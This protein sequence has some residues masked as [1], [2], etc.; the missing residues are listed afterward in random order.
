M[1]TFLFGILLSM[2]TLALFAQ[3]SSSNDPLDVI[4]RIATEQSQVADIASWITDVYGPRLTGSPM[5]D[6]AT[7]WATRTMKSWGMANVHL[8]EWRFGHTG[9]VCEKRTK[10][11]FPY[12]TP[13]L[14]KDYNMWNFLEW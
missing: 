13:Q 2:S 11:V 7:E 9:W 4:R 1:K 12:K 5:L 10:L 14:E 3:E 8:E 6:S